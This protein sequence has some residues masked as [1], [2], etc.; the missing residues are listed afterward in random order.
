MVI[1]GDTE[2]RKPDVAIYLIA[3]DELGVPPRECVFADDTAANLPVAEELGMA[4]VH[5]T[6]TAAGIRE[7]S[8]LLGLS[9]GFAERLGVRR[10]LKWCALIY[11]SMGRDDP[12]GRTEQ[13]PGRPQQPRGEQ[14]CTRRT[15]PRDLRRNCRAIEPPLA[16]LNAVQLMYAGAVL[17]YSR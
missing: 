5:F 12:P 3:T 16:V 15:R 17:R 8:R 9:L 10:F 7:I 6:D 11:R 4:T 2:T 14:P 13:L 1:S